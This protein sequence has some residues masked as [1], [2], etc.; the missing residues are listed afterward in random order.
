MATGFAPMVIVLYRSAFQLQPSL[1][2]KPASKSRTNKAYKKPSKSM[3]SA[4]WF[5]AGF[6]ERFSSPIIHNGSQCECKFKLKA[7]LEY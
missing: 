7:S 6:I 5:C 4:L 3:I 1:Y 2:Y